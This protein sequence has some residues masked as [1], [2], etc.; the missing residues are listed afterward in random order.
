VTQSLADRLLG[1]FG[2]LRRRLRAGLVQ[3]LGALARLGLGLLLPQ[4]TFE[5]TVASTL[6]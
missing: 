1:R 2:R 6:R 5:S 4:I 3:L